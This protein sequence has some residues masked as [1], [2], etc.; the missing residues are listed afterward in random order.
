[1]KSLLIC[2][3]LSFTFLW[4][5]VAFS[6]TPE[7]IKHEEMLSKL[8]KDRCDS[9]QIEGKD[10][11]I[12]FIGGGKV[13]V[14]FFG[15]KGGGIKGTFIYNK[16]EWEGRQRVLRKHQAL[17][18]K[19]RRKCIREELMLLR[20]SYKPPS[21]SENEI[22][23]LGQ[24]W[25]TALRN[26]DVDK[27]LWLSELPFIFDGMVFV[28]RNEL[29]KEY[30]DL[31]SG[32]YDDGAYGAWRHIGDP[33]EEVVVRG[34]SVH[35]IGDLSRN[36]VE[37]TKDAINTLHLEKADLGIKIKI[38]W[39]AKD[40]QNQDWNLEFILVALKSSHMYKIVGALH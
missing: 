10:Y 34:I 4:N 31:I 23:S 22:S 40:S 33:R 25:L 39:L 11:S 1:M 29:K 14:S 3:L 27:L 32:V 30:R 28:T 2:G 35:S 17:E 37:L 16:S 26:K 36:S 13:E 5:S 20:K 9:E 21:A 38:T 19:D 18:N 8:A 7:Q 15:K 24:E 6:L 12:K